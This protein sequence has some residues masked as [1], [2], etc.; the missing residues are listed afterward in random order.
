MSNQADPIK[1]SPPAK[2][3]HDLK[4]DPKAIRE[5]LRRAREKRGVKV[6]QSK[7]P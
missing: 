3:I 6:S 1:Q 4:F 2:D 7:L 5:A